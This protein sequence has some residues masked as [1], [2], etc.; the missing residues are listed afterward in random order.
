MVEVYRAGT[1]L[2]KVRAIMLFALAC[3]LGAIW[4]GWDLFQPHGL[5]PADGGALAPLG[6]RLA[7]G[8]GLAALGIAFAAAMW[9]YGRLYVSRLR[10]ERGSDRLLV[11]TLGFVGGRETP[12]PASDVVS[13]TYVAGRYDNPGG[14]SVD[15]PWMSLRM[16]GRRWPLIVDAQ[17]VFPDRELAARLLQP[18]R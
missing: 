9:A 17:G 3:A 11:R 4:W 13:S 8:L 12:Y 10:Y 16:A 1:Q 5:R 15:A 14:V 6:T 2:L 7:L 18:R